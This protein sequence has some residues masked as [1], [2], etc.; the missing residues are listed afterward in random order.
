M[1]ES[2]SSI[3]WGPLAWLLLGYITFSQ[4]LIVWAW[5][6]ILMGVIYNRVWFFHQKQK[7]D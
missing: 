3:I 7:M 4:W 2:L 6:I 5:L 1:V